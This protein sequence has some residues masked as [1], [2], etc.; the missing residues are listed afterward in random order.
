MRWVNNRDI[1]LAIESLS[2]KVDKMSGV[3]DADLAALTAA[4]TNMTSEV[5]AAVKEIQDLLASGQPS[6]D[7]LAQIT[8][9]TAAIEAANAALAAALPAPPPPSPPAA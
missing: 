7:Q 6:A 3:L 5:A 1:W 9:A 8:N 4:V 2:R